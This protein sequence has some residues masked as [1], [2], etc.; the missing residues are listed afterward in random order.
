MGYPCPFHLNLPV[1]TDIF[2]KICFVK[3]IM[4]AAQTFSRQC[5]ARLLQSVGDLFKFR[6]HGLS[7]QRCTELLQKI[8]DQICFC[9]RIFGLFQQMMD[10]KCLIA[11]RCHFCNKDPVTGINIR[12]CLVRIP[13]VEC[14]PHL[15]CQ[16]KYII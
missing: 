7:I 1:N 4:N 9:L 12:L 13:G 15:M 8:I 11:G 16:G 10:Q 14:M 5:F 2:T 3:V 6:K